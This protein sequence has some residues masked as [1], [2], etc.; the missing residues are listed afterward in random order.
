MVF[1]NVSGSCVNL[2]EADAQCSAVLQCFYPGAEGGNALADILFGK[3]S[4]SG[5]LPVTFYRSAGDLPDFADYS[6]EN[7]TYRFFKGK[8]LYPFGYGL[9]YTQFTET[10]LDEETVE[11]K[12]IGKMDSWH[13]VLKFKNDPVPTL[14]GFG[15]AFIPAGEAVVLKIRCN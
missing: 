15:K 8:P 5:R 13:S 9:S 6:M 2:C 10:W 7:R 11:V 3:A 12:N 14:V 1:V 4:P